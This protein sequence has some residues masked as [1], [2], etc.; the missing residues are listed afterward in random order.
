MYA[1]LVLKTKNYLN[2]QS[3]P[4]SIVY[5]A[6]YMLMLGSLV[7]VSNVRIHYIVLQIV[8]IKPQW[9]AIVDYKIWIRESNLGHT[10]NPSVGLSPF[11]RIIIDNN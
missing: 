7:L 1:F 2:N 10:L 5:E 9:Q 3:L 4:E 8:I 11:I 6:E